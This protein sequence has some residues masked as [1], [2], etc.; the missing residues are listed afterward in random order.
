M[1]D[2]VLKEENNQHNSLFSPSSPSPLL[3]IVA[4]RRKR[5]ASPVGPGR[6]AGMMIGLSIEFSGKAACGIGPN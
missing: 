3:L 4:S 2:V 1:L 5:E 6:P